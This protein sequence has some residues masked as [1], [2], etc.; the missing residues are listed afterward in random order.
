MINQETLWGV[1]GGGMVTH[2]PRPNV[3]GEGSDHPHKTVWRGL[4]VWPS[5][6]F[7]EPKAETKKAERKAQK[8][9]LMTTAAKKTA[10]VGGGGRCPSGGTSR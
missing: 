8:S 4:A 1:G 5:R 6:L 9:V 3:V 7:L 10:V 2:P